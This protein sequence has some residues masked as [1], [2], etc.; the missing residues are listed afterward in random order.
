MEEW[1]LTSWMDCRLIGCTVPVGSK[2][3]YQI[4]DVARKYMF[5]VHIYGTTWLSMIYVLVVNYSS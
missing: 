1:L 3:E 4:S 2:H 5:I